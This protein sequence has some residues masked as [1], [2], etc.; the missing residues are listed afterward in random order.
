MA[1][2]AMLAE[3]METAGINAGLDAACKR[4]VAN[5]LILAW[6][7]KYTVREYRD[8]EVSTIAE[9]FIEGEPV[10]SGAAVHQDEI[11]IRGETNQ[12]DTMTEG[13]VVYDIR[14]RAIVPRSGGY[15]ALIMN[16]EA[17]KDFYP[18]YP[19]I[20]RGIYYCCRMISGQYGTE[21]TAPHYEDI[22]KVYS[23]W[24]CIN[25]PKQRR[26]SI[27]E[28]CITENCKV[29][30]VREQT[31]NYDLLSAVMICLGEA[32]EESK[33]EEVIDLL[34]ILLTSKMDV[35]EKRSGWSR[36]LELE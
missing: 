30:N 24:I 2:K 17:Q 28:Y 16:V 23:I 8:Y 5:K 15:A 21:F 33:T 18:G 9:R 34:N 25:P 19:L 4:L 26:Y 32:P 27:A 22:H 10:M 6:I 11:Y 20:K 36:I 7:M 31:E 29:G 1:Q 3:R 13:T 35:E 14:F 12:D